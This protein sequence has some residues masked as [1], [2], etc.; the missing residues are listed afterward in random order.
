MGHQC[1][2]NG[3][4]QIRCGRAQDSGHADEGAAQRRE[5]QRADVGRPIAVV[6]AHRAFNHIVEHG[7]TFFDEHLTS[8]GALLQAFTQHNRRNA[9]QQHD[10]KGRDCRLGDAD[11]A[12]QR[13]GKVDFRTIHGVVSPS[14][15]VGSDSSLRK[16]S[17]SFRLT[18]AKS[19]G[20]MVASGSQNF[21]RNN[22]M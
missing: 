6:F 8:A 21:A 3:C 5:K 4:R 13:Y 15:F 19:S 12:E 14:F 18:C 10:H 17:I 16:N 20:R 11:A 2:G 22:K 1:P 7:H 9:E